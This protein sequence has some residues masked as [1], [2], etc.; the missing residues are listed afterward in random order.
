MVTYYALAETGRDSEPFIIT[1]D[2]RKLV[3]SEVIEEDAEQ[4]ILPLLN[5]AYSI[6]TLEPAGPVTLDGDDLPECRDG[7]TV[8]KLDGDLSP[9]FG[10]QAAQIRAAVAEAERVL[11]GDGDGET[12]QAY[13][14]AIDAVYEHGYPEAERMAIE[15]LDAY[16]A[17][18]CWWD[19]VGACAY[20]GEVKALAARDLIG[21]VPGWTQEAYDL[22]TGPWLAAFGR[23]V[24]PDDK[25][26]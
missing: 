24:H 13:A 11:I 3:P 6:A 23:P 8:T 10:P 1:T 20:G 17:D 15:A 25:D 2:P 16:G 4:A 12:A 22:L 19:E 7:W 18:G 9:M 14:D 21:T 5:P 26:R